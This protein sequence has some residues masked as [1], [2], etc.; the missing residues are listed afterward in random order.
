MGKWPIDTSAPAR[1]AGHAAF[2]IQNVLIVALAKNWLKHCDTLKG[3]PG[4]ASNVFI[5]SLNAA[6]FISISI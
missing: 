6:R 1:H 3:N 4:A 2:S 5:K